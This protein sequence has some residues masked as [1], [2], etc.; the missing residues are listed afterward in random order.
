MKSTVFLDVTPYSLVEVYCYF[1]ETY[2]LYFQGRKI[3]QA[4]KQAYN[5]ILIACLAYLSTLKMETA[6]SSET[7]EKNCKSYGFISQRI[8]LFILTPVR[9]SNLALAVKSMMQTTINL[10]ILRYYINC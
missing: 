4:R 8:V 2:R 6:R 1:G 9:A 5:R 3:G 10:I 7:S